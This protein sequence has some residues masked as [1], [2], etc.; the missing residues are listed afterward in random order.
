[1]RTCVIVCSFALLFGWSLTADGFELV[2]DPGHSPKSL[3]AVSCAGIP[4]YCY[5]NA[6]VASVVDALADLDMVRVQLSK[7]YTEEKSLRD[8]VKETAGRD[9]F[10]SIHHDSVQPRFLKNTSN[11]SGSCSDKASGFSIFVSRSNVFFGKSFAAASRLGRALMA[12]GL[13]PTLHHAESIEGEN[14]PL[15]D[16]ELGIYAFDH[17][18]VLKEANA[19]ALLLEAGVI[20]NPVDEKTIATEAFKAKIAQAIRAVVDTTAPDRGN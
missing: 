18:V 14:R 16:K 12:Q 2:L 1:V 9:L 15:L 17:L 5:N 19:P 8:R 6:L 13:K 4:E 3:G 11:G 10:I 20:V 7:G